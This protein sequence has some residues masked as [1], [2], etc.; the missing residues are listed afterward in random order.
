MIPD[1]NQN[2]L[3]PHSH[4]QS[5]PQF[6]ALSTGDLDILSACF[7]NLGVASEGGTFDPRATSHLLPLTETSA[8]TH[9]KISPYPC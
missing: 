7:A 3:G 8:C 6:A 5:P 4:H 2:S 9:T 1:L